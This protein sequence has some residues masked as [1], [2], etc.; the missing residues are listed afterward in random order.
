MPF[1]SLWAR[2]PL[3]VRWGICLLIGVA[4]VVALVAFVSHNNGNGLAHISAKNSAREARQ[5]QIII[6]QDQAPRTVHVRGHDAVAALV[7]GVRHDMRRRIATGNLDGPLRSVR[8]GRSGARGG[9]IGYHCLAEADGVRYP[10]L[11]IFTP[12]AHRAAY[13]KKDFAPQE[14][15]NIPVSARCLL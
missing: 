15:E 9:R 12:A 1:E 4:V 11:A 8:C 6:G 14:G 2:I 13:C 3:L 7:A 10:F 5:A